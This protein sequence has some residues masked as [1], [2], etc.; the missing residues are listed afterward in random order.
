MEYVLKGPTIDSS[1]IYLK[2]Q[3]F[4]LQDVVHEIEEKHGIKKVVNGKWKVFREI[5]R[6]NLGI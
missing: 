6:N 2:Y 1:M 5:I 3:G 4:T